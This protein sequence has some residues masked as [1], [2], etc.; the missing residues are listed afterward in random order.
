MSTIPFVQQLEWADCGA[1]SLAMVL[2]FHGKHVGL[3]RVRTA[4]A[5]SRDGVSARARSSTPPRSWA[6]RAAP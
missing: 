4:L 6:C 5:V 1:A 3:D 2:G